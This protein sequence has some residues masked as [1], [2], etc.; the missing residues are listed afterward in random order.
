MNTN[1]INIA[2]Y[3]VVTTNTISG[4]NIN[5][6]ELVLFTKVVLAVNLLDINRNFISMKMMTLTG[7]DYANW[8]NDDTYINTYVAKQLEITLLHNFVSL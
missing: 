8:A 3:D 2:C 5:V 6:L 1:T 4:F 7:E